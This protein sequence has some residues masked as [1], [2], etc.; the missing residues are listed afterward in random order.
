M[1]KGL[2]V[3]LLCVAFV[4]CFSVAMRQAAAQE[5]EGEERAPPREEGERAPAFKPIS[6]TLNPLGIGILQRYGANVEYMVAKHHG[7]WLYPFFSSFSVESSVNGVKSSTD[8]TS[9]GGEIGYH[10]YTGSKGANGF[11]VG[12]T[13]GVFSVSSKASGSGASESASSTAAHIGVDLGGQHVFDNGIT[14][15]GGFGVMNFVASG[16]TNSDSSTTSFKGTLPRFLFT[17]GYSF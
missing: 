7:L 16:K 6:I 15:G 9:Y 2:K 14:L 1:Q 12:P 5:Q 8:F 4:G 11:F 3:G 10:F 13:A 17:V